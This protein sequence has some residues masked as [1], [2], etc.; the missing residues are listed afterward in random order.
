MSRKGFT[1]IELIIVIVIIGIIAAIAA[2][3]IFG[4]ST[5]SKY[6]TEFSDN[7]SYCESFLR[8]S[9]ID[10]GLSLIRIKE[11]IAE[12][13]PFDDFIRMECEY[14]GH[15]TAKLLMEMQKNREPIPNDP[16]VTP[17]PKP[18]PYNKTGWKVIKDKNVLF[19]NTQSDA[20]LADVEAYKKQ[21]E[22][23]DYISIKHM[24]NMTDGILVEF[25]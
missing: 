24:V 23:S 11:L 25:R 19:Y 7:K 21:D 20:F 22:L 14:N 17:T 1:F 12:S 8:E 4:L 10:F 3:K 6:C 13:I 9:R 5:S 16:V 2:P 15:C 18:I